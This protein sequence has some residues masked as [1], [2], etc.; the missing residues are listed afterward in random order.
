MSK[1]ETNVGVVI[2][3]ID[4]YMPFK[5][6]CKDKSIREVSVCHRQGITV[7][8][9]NEKSTVKVTAVCCGVGKVNAAVITTA[10]CLAG[11]DMIINF[12]LSG[13]ISKVAKNDITIPD[14]FI[15]H[16]FDLTGIGYKLCE[17]PGQ[18]YIYTADKSVTDILYEVMPFAKIGT[19]VSGD[20]FISD[21]VKR[22]QL[23]T[24]FNAVSCD[25]ETAAIAYSAKAC[26]IPFASFRK[27]SDNAGDD[28]LDSYRQVNLSGDTSLSEY[29]DLF[30]EKL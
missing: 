22:E 16:D 3:D 19:A 15:E 4:E 14:M 10:L 21:N 23:K 13:G 26:G 5:N 20:C 9:E 6:H 30:I 27:I 18:E 25:M 28:S 11:A 8:Y 29:F 2:A 17:K 1:K 24:N 7:D 12:G